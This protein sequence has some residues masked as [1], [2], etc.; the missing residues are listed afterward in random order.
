MSC[1]YRYIGASSHSIAAA[2]SHCQQI[3]ISEEPRRIIE[4]FERSGELGGY[5]RGKHG[6]I[7]SCIA[8]HRRSAQINEY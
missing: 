8:N 3:V 6:S 5:N 7:L 2:W 1:L 4:G